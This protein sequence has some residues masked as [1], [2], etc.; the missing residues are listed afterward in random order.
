MVNIEFGRTIYIYVMYAYASVV[1]V[2]VNALNY[3]KF[4]N[5]FI[6]NDEYYISTTGMCSIGLMNTV[7]YD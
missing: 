1:F 3:H 5:I 2:L 7:L 6:I 4:V